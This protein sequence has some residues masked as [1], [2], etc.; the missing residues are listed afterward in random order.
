MARTGSLEGAKVDVACSLAPRTYDFLNSIFGKS[1][2]IEK[3][4]FKK[5]RYFLG[6]MPQHSIVKLVPCI[7]WLRM[8]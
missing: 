3:T 4:D 7:R 2:F 5:K 8:G 1:K 6:E